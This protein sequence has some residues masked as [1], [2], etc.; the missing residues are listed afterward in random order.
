MFYD[1]KISE[2]AHINYL[3]N[4][5]YCD[6]YGIDILVSNLSTYK[7]RHPAWERLPLILNNIQ[8]YEYIIWIDSDAFF[9]HNSKNII[10]IINNNKDT[11]F[12]FTYDKLGKFVNSGIFIV[13]NTDYSINFIKTW[14]FDE[15]LYKNNSNPELWEQ[16]VLNDMIDSNLFDI[17]N[18]SFIYNYDILQRQD[19]YFDINELNNPNNPYVYHSSGAHFNIKL[20]TAKKYYEYLISNN[21]MKK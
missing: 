13:K 20:S 4:K 11:N 9:Y 1:N 17:K 7:D 10:D 5:M 19:N 18:N 8:N 21:I 16:G 2:F 6:K 3:I 15:N 12:I 14:A